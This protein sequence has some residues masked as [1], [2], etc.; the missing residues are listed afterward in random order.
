MTFT[1]SE[2]NLMSIG[3]LIVLDSIF[4]RM[5]ENRAKKRKTYIFIDEIICF[6]NMNTRQNFLFSLWKR[7]RKYG[8]IYHRYYT[9]FGGYAAK[10]HGENH[11]C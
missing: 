8:A 11:A 1:N 5:I 7:V 9:K 4:N 10:P 6:S 2:N 3:M